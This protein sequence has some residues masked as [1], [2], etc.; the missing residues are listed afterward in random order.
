MMMVRAL[1]GT[2]KK[3]WREGWGGKE[4]KHTCKRNDLSS[5][6]ACDAPFAIAPPEQIRQPGPMRRQFPPSRASCALSVQR[7]QHAQQ[8]PSL[9]LIVRLRP[10]LRDGICHVGAGGGDELAG[11][12]GPLGDLVRE[13]F[14]DGGGGEDACGRGGKVFG[15]DAVVEEGGEDF[16]LKGVSGGGGLKAG[17]GEDFTAIFGNFAIEAASGTVEEVREVI[18]LSD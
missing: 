14:G 4:R 17:G 16:F 9:R 7:R 8:A 15:G 1:P 6:H 3:K 13:C 11:E 18:A 12:I 10:Q 5:D 2:E